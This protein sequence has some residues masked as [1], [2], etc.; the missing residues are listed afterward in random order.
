MAGIRRTWDKEYFEQKARDRVEFGDDFVDQKD[1]GGG[2]VRKVLKPEFQKAEEDAPGPMGSD[3]AFI[4]PRDYK[5]ELDDKVGKVEVIN[6]LTEDGSKAGF[7]CEPCKCL[8]KDSA[9][10]LDH[11]NGKKRKLLLYDLL[12]GCKRFVFGRSKSSWFQH[13]S[14]TS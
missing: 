9:S 12:F 7:W 11:L 4:K 13:A 10:Y 8:L 5:L 2:K 6:P 14:A 3:K 1:A